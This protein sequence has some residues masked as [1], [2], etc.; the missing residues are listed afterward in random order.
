MSVEKRMK[1][2]ECSKEN[3]KRMQEREREQKRV[4]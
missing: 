4:E 2:G 1:R 3:E